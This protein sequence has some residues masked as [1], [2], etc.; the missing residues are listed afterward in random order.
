MSYTL[1]L[2][3]KSPFK[4]TLV[5]KFRAAGFGLLDCSQ[6]D[7]EVQLLDKVPD[8]SFV[9][10]ESEKIETGSFMDIELGDHCW[11]TTLDLPTSTDLVSRVLSVLN[12]LAKKSETLIVDPQSPTASRVRKV[13][14]A[15]K[16][17]GRKKLRFL[18]VLEENLF[19][20]DDVIRF[21]EQ[22]RD[23]LH[24]P[25]VFEFGS[26]E[27]MKFRFDDRSGL[28]KEGRTALDRATDIYVRSN[29]PGV[30]SVLYLS[31]AASS[32]TGFM[33]MIELTIDVTEYPTD[34]FEGL[35][36]LFRR[37]CESYSCFYGGVTFADNTDQTPAQ[38]YSETRWRLDRFGFWN[39]I[40]ANYTWLTWFG[41]DLKRKVEEF[42]P[43]AEAAG[44]ALFMRF[45]E[46]PQ[47]RAQL[48]TKFPQFPDRMLDLD[49]DF[50]RFVR[51]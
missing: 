42:L 21:W 36:L 5:S 4:Q 43:G 3:S 24:R 12:K 17:K 6:D 19:T 49:G 51:G 10:F 39:G 46:Q 31:P 30:R 1:Y 8:L 7:K 33:S 34:V 48:L 25:Y 2:L 13:G 41:E 35:V 45:G 44:S 29:P 16:S 22:L 15:F 14:P 23:V 47:T 18:W 38:E 20:T 50:D 37:M 40:P 11:L 32:A 26:S 9:V 28:S 27:T